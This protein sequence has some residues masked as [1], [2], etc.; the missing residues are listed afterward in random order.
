MLPLNWPIRFVQV[1]G[2][3]VGLLECAW[4]GNIADL[5]TEHICQSGLFVEN[6]C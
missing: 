6:L 1:R 3:N 4:L 5:L 2:H